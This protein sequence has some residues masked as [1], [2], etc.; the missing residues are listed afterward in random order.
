[1]KLKNQQGIAHLTAVLVIILVA[2]IALG[3]WRVMSS[4]NKDK[5]SQSQ[6]ELKSSEQSNDDAEKTY[7]DEAAKFSIKYP[8]TWKI[9]TEKT[10]IDQLGTFTDTTLTSPS[11]TELNITTGT[12]GRGGDC[13]PEKNDTPFSPSNACPSKEFYSKEPVDLGL[14]IRVFLVTGKY[15]V[16]AVSDRSGDYYFIGL[17]GEAESYTI[18][19][20]APVMGLLSDRSFFNIITQSFDGEVSTFASSKDPNFLK[21]Q[22]AKEIMAIL[23]SLHF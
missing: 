1:M 23:K 20:N 14:P 15:G 3:A 13:E 5:Q 16:P 22:D 9:K 12:G 18:S 2:V 7:T 10:E 6:S 21:S 4:S 19:L 17:E 8:G 11:G